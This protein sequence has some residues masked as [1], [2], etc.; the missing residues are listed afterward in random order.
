VGAAFLEFEIVSGNDAV[1]GFDESL[2][3]AVD[4]RISM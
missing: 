4:M 1:A 2:G 3:D